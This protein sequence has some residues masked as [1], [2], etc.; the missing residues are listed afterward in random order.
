MLN[1]EEYI[2]SILLWIMVTIAFVNVVSR[3]TFNFSI[4]F[5]EELTVNLFVWLVLFGTAIAFKKW[6]HLAVSIVVD[7]LPNKLR[8]GA[9][10]FGNI[11]IIFFFIMLLYFGFQQVQDEVF[12][13]IRTTSMGI[14]KWWYTIG[15]P[16]G[17]IIIILRVLQRSYKVLKGENK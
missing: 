14:P 1:F 11:I 16:I 9:E 17:S 2:A 5:V 10:L 7:N 13:G 8:K 12:M 3:F 6:N 15:I 4:G